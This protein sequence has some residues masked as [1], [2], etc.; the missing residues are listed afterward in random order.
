MREKYQT[1]QILLGNGMTK[2]TAKSLIDNCPLD[3]VKPLEF[4]LREAVKPRKA[5]QN[6]LMWSGPLADIAQQAWVQGRTFSAETWHE[7]FKRE[8]L[9]ESHIEGMTKEGYQKWDI[10]PSGERVLIGSTTDLTVRGF[11]EYLEQI[12]AYGASL[13][14]RFHTVRMAA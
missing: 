10:T 3:P 7:H 9:P 2:E 5:D 11:S 14:V 4:I 8:F 13:G 6:A 1:R 12:H